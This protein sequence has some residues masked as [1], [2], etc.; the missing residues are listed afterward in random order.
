MH[1]RCQRIIP[2]DD[3][4]MGAEVDLSQAFAPFSCVRSSFAQRRCRTDERR[5]LDLR[6]VLISD[7]DDADLM[8]PIAC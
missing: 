6:A 5:L 3:R 4:A 8:T 1:N 2:A 7:D